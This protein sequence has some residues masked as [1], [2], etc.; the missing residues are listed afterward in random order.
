MWRACL[1]PCSVDTCCSARPITGTF[2]LQFLAEFI[3]LESSAGLSST[4]ELRWMTNR[5]C[6]TG[7]TTYDS[8]ANLYRA[9]DQARLRSEA[10]T[11]VH[12][13]RRVGERKHPRR[14]RA[15]IARQTRRAY[16]ASLCAQILS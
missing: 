2:S 16:G 4:P 3:F 11:T 13:D 10:A 9:D 1:H 15:G 7:A 12:G 6:N 14:P 8:N 5:F